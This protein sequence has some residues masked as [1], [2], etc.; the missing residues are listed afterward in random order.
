MKSIPFTQHIQEVNGKYVVLYNT[1]D[2]EN[3][4][5]G[6]YDTLIE[7]LM[8]RDEMAFKNYPEPQYI[9]CTGNNYSI[10]KWLNGKNAYFGSYPTLSEAKRM[11]KYFEKKGWE[12]CLN[13]RLR[14]TNVSN[15]IFD[16][17][18]KKFVIVKM[19]NKKII[20]FG[21]FNDYETAEKE[22]KLLKKCNWDIDALCEGIDESHDG[23]KYL[24]GKKSK[25]SFYRKNENGTDDTFWFYNG[26]KKRRSKYN[27]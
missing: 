22:V 9:Q 19:I 26:I 18:I 13:E 14:Y 15:I 23:I 27:G 5:Y 11:V 1:N 21:T 20:R 4:Y 8:V 10:R 7:A 24:D 17:R 2:G 3:R 12:N 6:Q 25:K 16:K